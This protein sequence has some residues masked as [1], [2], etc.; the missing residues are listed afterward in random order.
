MEGII[1]SMTTTPHRIAKLK[2]VIESLL[3]Q[4]VVPDHILV[5]LPDVF[6]RDES[7]YPSM[8]ALPDWLLPFVHRYKKDMGPITKLHPSIVMASKSVN[9]LIITVDDDIA[10]P[11]TLVEI[12]TEYAKRWDCCVGAVG[13]EEKSMAPVRQH[14]K[15]C[16]I[17]EGWAGVCYHSRFFFPL[18]SWEEYVEDVTRDADARLSDDLTISLWLS[19]RR[20][21]RKVVNTPS[22]NREIFYRKG[23]ILP[24]GQEHDA[25]HLGG[26]GKGNNIL[27]YRKAAVRIKRGDIGRL[28]FQR[29]STDGILS[30]HSQP[31]F[32]WSMIPQ[33]HTHF[34]WLHSGSRSPSGHTIFSW[35]GSIVG[36]LD[37]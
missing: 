11:P 27:R 31:S 34:S 9:N 8:V 2:V 32:R 21:Q 22:L 16:S 5:H 20:V 13:L 19:A 33:G 15:E 18:D 30:D 7:T 35:T 37:M 24:H 14:G 10:Y 3:N 4:T 1:V 25:L 28:N 6:E 36:T 12:L 17:L 29:E 26:G 23:V